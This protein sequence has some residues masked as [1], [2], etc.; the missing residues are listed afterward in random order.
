MRKESRA[1]D[2]PHLNLYAK[3]RKG[4]LI[5]MTQ[6]HIM[7]KHAGGSNDIDNLQTMCR[8]CNSYK[9]GMLPHEY[10]EIAM[11]HERA[12]YLGGVDGGGSPTRG[13]SSLH[14]P[15]LNETVTSDC[16]AE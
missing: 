5:L 7:P 8:C 9:G 16:A 3:D 4:T 14:S 1:Y 12:T 6:D 11:P 10:A 13:L 15:I 2:T